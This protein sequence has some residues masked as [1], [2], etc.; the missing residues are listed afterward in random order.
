[1][2]HKNDNENDSSR[3]PETGKRGQP[4]PNT[5]GQK[6]QVSYEYYIEY[7]YS[8]QSPHH[9]DNTHHPNQD[10]RRES[11]A[12][13]DRCHIVV[14]KKHITATQKIGKEHQAKDLRP[15]SNTNDGKTPEVDPKMINNIGKLDSRAI[16]M[17][18]VR[19]LTKPLVEE[20]GYSLE[21]RQ[22]SVGDPMR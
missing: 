21:I 16:E 20:Y 13:S 5:F 17:N 9:S 19:V 7:E 4:P 6:P 11:C 15:I 3:Y 2:I 10:G 22:Q 18:L 1:M 14:N 8:P 12:G